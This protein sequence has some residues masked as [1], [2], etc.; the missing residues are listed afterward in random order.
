MTFKI[1]DIVCYTPEQITCTIIAFW[2]VD[3]KLQRHD[4]WKMFLSSRIVPGECGTSPPTPPVPTY[5]IPIVQ[6]DIQT[7]ATLKVDGVEVI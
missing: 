7:G 3:Y 1:G 2:G 6:F 5:D 4:T